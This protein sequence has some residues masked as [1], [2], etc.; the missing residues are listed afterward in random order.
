MGKVLYKMTTPYF[1][2][3]D[4]TIIDVAKQI[5]QPEGWVLYLE[6]IEN[7]LRL[8]AERMAENDDP[9]PGMF[10]NWIYFDYD[11]CYMTVGVRVD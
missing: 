1:G 5:S 7:E 3:K 9:T 10:D 8:V 4:A 2:E 11:F 6:P